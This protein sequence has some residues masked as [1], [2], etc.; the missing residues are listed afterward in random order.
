MTTYA[1]T[2]PATGEQIRSFPTHTDAEVQD[3]VGRADD[4]FRT[5][6]RSASVQERAA[7]VARVAQLH[8]DRREDLAETMV[9][10]MGKPREEALGEVDFSADIYDYYAQNAADFLADEPVALLGGEGTAVVKKRPLGVL[11]GIMPWNFPAYQVARFA[12]P[13]L[14]AGNTIVLKHA[15]QCPESAAALEQL[16]AD[17]G[18]PAAPTSTSTPATS[19]SRA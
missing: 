3:A 13:N 2:D 8:R 4:A 19:R 1:V 12:G 7:L 17:A 10:E 9:R 6:S 18:F 15:P 16:F 11:L 14:A 5:W